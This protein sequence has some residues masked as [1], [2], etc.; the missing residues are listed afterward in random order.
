MSLLNLNLSCNFRHWDEFYKKED[1]KTLSDAGIT[2]LRI[3]IGYWLVDVVETEP[4][5]S[6][7]TNDD[8][9]QRFYLKRLLGWAKDLELKVQPFT[10]VFL[11]Q[12]II[13]LYNH[14][15]SA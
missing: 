2:H 5:P 9:G 13:F 4:F 8:E 3:P 7:P 15:I 1:L 14:Q 6:P 10:I 12:K 11:I